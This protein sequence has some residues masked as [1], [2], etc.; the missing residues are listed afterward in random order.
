MDGGDYPVSMDFDGE[1]GMEVNANKVK[2]V[3]EIEPSISN[4]GGEEHYSNGMDMD[5]EAEF[6]SQL[7]DLNRSSNVGLSEAIWSAPPE[8]EGDSP[9]PND[10]DI[11]LHEED[12]EDEGEPEVEEPAPL[13]Y[14]APEV[15]EPPEDVNAGEGFLDNDADIATEGSLDL[16]I[17]EPDHQRLTDRYIPLGAEL[18]LGGSEGEQEQFSVENPETEPLQPEP[19]PLLQEPEPESLLEEPEPSQQEPA[20]QDEFEDEF[21][22]RLGAVEEEQQQLLL[23]EGV[24]EHEVEAGAVTEGS[25]DLDVGAHVEDED[26]DA[27]IVDHISIHLF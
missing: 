16:D 27:G 22:G 6:D 7:N 23:D 12:E 10:P 8:E 21:D 14:D 18:D 3:D 5:L 20:A 1:F 15:E 2:D 4:G 25:L 13:V 17:D 11:E 19:E 26:D 24:P 9:T